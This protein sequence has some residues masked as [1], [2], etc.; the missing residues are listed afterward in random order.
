MTQPVP[1]PDPGNSP[2]QEWA[3]ELPPDEEVDVELLLVA[4]A[5]LDEL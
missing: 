4:L 2:P 1:P 5:G 3:E